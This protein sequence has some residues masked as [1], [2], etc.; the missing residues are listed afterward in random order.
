[1]FMAHNLPNF[2]V[3][4]LFEKYILVSK[5]SFEYILHAQMRVHTHTHPHTHP[6]THRHR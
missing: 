6:P 3:E 5:E 1:M 2:P 4:L